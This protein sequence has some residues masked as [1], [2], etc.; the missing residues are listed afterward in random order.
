MT[1][2]TPKHHCIICSTLIYSGIYCA[3][4]YFEMT[5]SRYIDEE[6]FEDWVVRNKNPRSPGLEVTTVQPLESFVK[7]DPRHR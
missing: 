1:I 2:M 6:S 5:R 4:C 3:S 7:A